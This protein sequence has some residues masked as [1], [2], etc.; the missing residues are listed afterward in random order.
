MDRDRVPRLSPRCEKLAARSPLCARE[1]GGAR[2]ASTT[3]LWH[4]ACSRDRQMLASNAH[5]ELW[6]LL[7]TEQLA[8]ARPRL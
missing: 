1:I 4:E 5:A 2:D 7:F 3:E 6:F 8:I